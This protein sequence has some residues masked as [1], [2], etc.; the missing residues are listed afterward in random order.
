M[1]GRWQRAGC[2]RGE[3]KG[4][5]FTRPATGSIGSAARKNVVS[6]TKPAKLT[7]RTVDRGDGNERRLASAARINEAPIERS[8]SRRR[9]AVGRVAVRRRRRFRHCGRPREQRDA[10]DHVG[11]TLRAPDHRMGEDLCQIGLEPAGVHGERPFGQQNQV[12]H[13]VERVPAAQRPRRAPLAVRLGIAERHVTLAETDADADA[14]SPTLFVTYR[15]LPGAL[16]SPPSPSDSFR[17]RALALSKS[18]SDSWA[19]RQ[20]QR[21]APIP[22]GSS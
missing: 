12:V 9:R 18:S 5:S 19:T 21:V 10:A 3:R 1:S 7:R 20:R 14:H 17:F 4:T 16:I 15:P 22:L 8:A 13:L 11:H 2:G 6:A